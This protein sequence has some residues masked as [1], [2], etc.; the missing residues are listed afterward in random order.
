MGDSSHNFTEFF[1][2]CYWRDSH[3]ED[4]LSFLSKNK[5]LTVNLIYNSLQDKCYK[6]L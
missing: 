3:R 6:G 2:L 5:Y 1:K 4:F